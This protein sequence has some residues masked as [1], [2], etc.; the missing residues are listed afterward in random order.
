M[1]TVCLYSFL[2][3]LKFVTF[4]T[5]HFE[6]MNFPLSADSYELLNIIGKGVY[7]KV[8]EA[9]CKTNGQKLCIKL[10]NLEDFPYG[11]ENLQKQTAL[12]S[13]CHN[14]NI[15]GYYGSFLNGSTVWILEEYMDGGSL[16]D[17]IKYGYNRGI[18]DENVC[19][20]IISGAL[21]A[22]D[23]FHKNQQIHRNVKSCNILLNS[24]GQVKLADFGL[25]TSM[26]QG[27][28]K[29][30]ACLSM[31]GDAC[32]M[33]PEILKNGDGYSPKSDIW[34][35][36]LTSIE[37]GTGKMPYEG[38]KMME[39]IVNIIDREPPSLPSSFSP[40]F[41]DFVHKCLSIAPQRRGSSEELLNHK[42][43]KNATNGV[44]GTAEL[45]NA[46]PPLGERF[47][48]MFPNDAKKFESIKPSPKS[49]KTEFTFDLPDE[50]E[51]D[52]PIIVEKM[53]EKVGRFNIQRTPSK[54]LITINPPSSNGS[55]NSQKGSQPS[56]TIGRRSSTSEDS[57]TLTKA[58][59]S[60]KIRELASEIKVLTSTLDK[61]ESE[62]NVL[63]D[64][65]GQI[66]TMVRNLS[67]AQ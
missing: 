51:L 20:N 25:A 35:L 44:Q 17:I 1:I 27:G 45:V 43:I 55:P 5:H 30:A 49:E 54:G 47:K 23:Y 38:M 3:H 26:I 60:K 61:L 37:I 33:S 36:G 41:Q 62:H 9:K 14:P 15:V 2:F 50:S 22:L 10:V 58:D 39:S 59:A 42:F 28:V 64:R 18:R 24:K 4:Y 19:A 16:E 8:Y 66:I 52:Q 57:S 7:S 48:I 34:S 56:I 65:L 40:A 13:K 67:T 12:W 32:Y 63:T 29:K 31:F 46:L 53:P 6:F 11:V 21:K